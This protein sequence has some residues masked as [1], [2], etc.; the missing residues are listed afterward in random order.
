[1]GKIFISHAAK[2]KES[3]DFFTSLFSPTKVQ[4]VFE[5]FDSK[6]GLQI[7]SAKITEDI[8][9]SNAVFILLDKSIENTKHTRDWIAFECGT[10]SGLNK[11]VWV[12][13]KIT[14]FSRVTIVTPSLK[15]FVTYRTN[16][17]WYKYI[18]EIVQSYDDS[19]ALATMV[20]TTTAGA[21]LAKDKWTGGLVGLGAGL[22][23]ANNNL[24]NTGS[25]VKCNGCN[26]IYNIHIPTGQ[27]FRCPV[28]NAKY[29][30]N[31]VIK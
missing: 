31:N 1:M 4:A 16:N 3:V 9:A 21:A 6:M 30:M 19:N 17:D 24:K 11:D 22:I 29:Q 26:S 20:L 25:R 23:L 10:A 14:D 5:E 15:H 28:C 12:F 8:K 7:N 18:R 27:Y 13:E 2:D